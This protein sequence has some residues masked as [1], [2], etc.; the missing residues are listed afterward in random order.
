MRVAVTGGSGQLGTLLLRRLADDRRVKE[1]VALDL[2][3]P[4]IVSGKLRDVRADVRD[5]GIGEH[6]R[7]C[8]A[9][10]HLAFLVAKRGP[11]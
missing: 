3:P 7:G 4:L 6:L 2:R 11:R 5:P 8:E 10:I 1:I 9:L